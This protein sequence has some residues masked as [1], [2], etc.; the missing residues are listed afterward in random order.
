MPSG[1]VRSLDHFHELLTIG[2]HPKVELDF[3]VA[4]DDSLKITAEFGDIDARI[5]RVSE[6]FIIKIEPPKA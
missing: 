5:T 3:D 4:T 6:R 2:Q 1:E